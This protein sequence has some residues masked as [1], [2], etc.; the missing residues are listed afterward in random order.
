MLSDFISRRE[1]YGKTPHVEIGE[2]GL[3]MDAG[4]QVILAEVQK[5]VL[6]HLN[7]FSV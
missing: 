7:F 2:H 5:E 6:R 3:F 1:I 4:K